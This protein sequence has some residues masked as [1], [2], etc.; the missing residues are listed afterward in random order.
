[1][2]RKYE[3]ISELYNQTVKE[4][5]SNPDLWRSFL[6]SASNNF[7]LRFD[8]QVL[9]FAQKPEATA[10]LEINRWNR[11]FG[12]WVN[13]GATGIAVFEDLSG[14][15]QRLNHYFDISDT[16]T[17]EK[18]RPVPIWKMNESYIEDVIET[19]E[20]TFGE[21]KNKE[22]FS[23]AVMS[24]AE[25]AVEDNIPD[26][27]GDLL[28]AIDNSFLEDLPDESVTA[29]YRQLVTNSVAYMIMTRLDLNPDLVLDDDDFRDESP[30][31][32]SNPLLSKSPLND[33]SA[34]LQSARVTYTQQGDYRLPNLTIPEQ[35]TVQLGHYARMRQKYLKE[36]HR[37]IY[38]NYL[39]SGTLANHLAD[40][41]QRAEQ[42]EER[43]TDE[44]AKKQNLT[45]KLKAEN[46]M[47][48]IGLM[49]NIRNSAQEIVKAEVIFA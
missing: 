46:P 8:E 30:N 32:S 45:E 38:Y 34:E 12:R 11:L 35:P 4:I 47:K 40:T 44:M 15:S 14:E 3:R 48:W 5:S 29:L 33:I 43:L 42:M 41:Q 7:K 1:M 26:Y 20:N 6:R 10:V 49:N 13:R 9:V 23:D 25:N 37:V 27:T 36:H 19:L 16:H 39:T 21:L 28:Q 22:T 17:G 18:S 24:A 2:A 31:K